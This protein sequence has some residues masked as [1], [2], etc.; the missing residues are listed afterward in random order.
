MKSLVN[1]EEWNESSRTFKEVMK[2][3]ED[4]QEDWW[5]SLSEEERLKAFCCISRRIYQGEF[6]ERRSYR[7]MLYDVMGFGPEAYAQAQDAGYLEIHNAL[8]VGDKK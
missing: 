6:V 3:I 7:G 4:Y 8:Y 2:E 1:S 5:N